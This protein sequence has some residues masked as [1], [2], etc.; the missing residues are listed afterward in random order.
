MSDVE[1]I[2]LYRYWSDSRIYKGTVIALSETE[3]FSNPIIVYNSDVENKH[4]LGKGTG[5]TYT[6]TAAGK[7]FTLNKVTKAR[8]VRVYMHGS[9]KGN[10]N[11][12][13]ELEVIGKQNKDPEVAIDIST[14]IDRLT[15]LSEVDT[16]N[17]TKNSVI[18]FN[19]LMKE[20]YDL[21]S[22]VKTE[23]DINSMIA[24]LENAES[25]LVDTSNLKTAIQEAKD[26]VAIKTTSSSQDLIAKIEEA[27]ALLING[28]TDSITIII[29]EL[30][31][32][33]SSDKLVDRGNVEALAD[34]I[35][36]YESLKESD[37]TKESWDLY[38][39]KLDEAVAIVE[40]NS[41]SSQADVDAAKSALE[42]A[43]NNLV[44][45]P[46]VTE[47]N[48]DALKKAIENAD[49]VEKNVYTNT[50]YDFM[51]SAYNRAI[52]FMT[53]NTVTQEQ[54]NEATK[55]LEDSLNALEKRADVTEGEKLLTSI[56]EE[57]LKADEY[58]EESWNTFAKAKAALEAAVKD[59]S[60]IN[61][62][63]I[64]KLI[65]ALKEA[66]YNLNKATPKVDKSE[67]ES[68]YNANKDKKD[69]G[70]TS[71]TFNTFQNALKVADAILKN[72]NATQEQIDNALA[73]LTKAIEELEEKQ[74]P[75]T[76]EVN[77]DKL[78]EVY[79]ANKNK[80]K[81]NYTEDSWKIFNNALN[82]AKAVLD[83]KDA[84]KED[85]DKA[86]ANLEQSIKN[87]KEKTKEPST[88]TEQPGNNENKEE[89]GNNSSGTNNLPQTGGSNPMA[90]VLSAILLVVVGV[91][92]L[93][94]K[95]RI[96][97][98]IK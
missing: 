41:N 70:Y 25:I 33:K 84:I 17:A 55:L 85:V 10:T 24:K 34:L 98:N 13:V 12:I 66:K 67:L 91:F 95:K 62:T 31:A 88:D 1:S 44:K 51:K 42:S 19:K 15:V 6:E 76:E 38:K 14:L 59:N 82:E 46:V 16:T 47:V 72:E 77:K 7:I 36:S 9:N 30:N 71:S 26:V 69:E 87:L 73:N 96:N 5:S 37:Y 8:Y 18:E 4:G 23:E 83:N 90:G 22:N 92:F 39:A 20:G 74:E 65:E 64:N 86:L 45:A 11:H 50:S 94:N 63:E 21:L 78:Q 48:K 35:N 52:E 54:I 81:E 2:N 68:L 58:T 53:S 80:K 97:N 49:K 27:E 61:E 89:S 93:F 43:K 40:D 60:N 75:P 32:D 28:T 3:D 56:Q 57:D 29:E 79:N